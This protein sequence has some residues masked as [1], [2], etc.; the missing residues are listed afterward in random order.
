MARL[1]QTGR[2]VAQCSRH[3]HVYTQADHRS[4]R[5]AWHN[6]PDDHTGLSAP[7]SQVAPCWGLVSGPSIRCTAIL[8]V[9]M[10]MAGEHSGQRTLPR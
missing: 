1:N 4:R 7:M 8:Q 5:I 2:S 3:R 6:F 9:E 10:N